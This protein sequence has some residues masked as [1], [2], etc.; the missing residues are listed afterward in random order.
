L[1]RPRIPWV[2]LLKEKS[3]SEGSVAPPCPPA[4]CT[5][6]RITNVIT[7]AYSMT[8]RVVCTTTEGRRPRMESQSNAPMMAAAM[9]QVTNFGKVVLGDTT[10]S[11]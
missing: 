2:L 11:R 5:R 6:A 8:I 1:A 4:S 3:D 7:D 10:N 9:I